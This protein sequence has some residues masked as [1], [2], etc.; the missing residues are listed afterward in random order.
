[1][2]LQVAALPPGLSRG[3]T[4]RAM[5]LEVA[6]EAGPSTTRTAAALAGGDTLAEAAIHS[7]C[8]V[9]ERRLAAGCDPNDPT[10]FFADCS[11]LYWAVYYGHQRR[12]GHFGCD[13]EIY[14]Q[15][16]A[17]WCPGTVIAT[18]EDGRLT[19]EYTVVRTTSALTLRRG[20]CEKT[21]VTGDG[22]A[23]ACPAGST[24]FKVLPASSDLLRRRSIVSALLV[25]GADPE[26]R[27]PRGGTTPL[28]IA[29]EHGYDDAVQLLLEQRADPNVADT[30]GK[31][32]LICAARWGKAACQ[33]ALLAAGADPEIRSPYEGTAADA[34]QEFEREAELK[35]QAEDDRVE[36]RRRFDQRVR[37]KEEALAAAEAAARLARWQAGL[38]ARRA[39]Y[40]VL[41][42]Q[43]ENMPAAEQQQQQQE[44]EHAAEH[45]AAEEHSKMDKKVGKAD[46]AQHDKLNKELREAEEEARE[47][48]EK[49]ER[50]VLAAQRYAEERDQEVAEVEQQH[51]EVQEKASFGR[52]KLQVLGSVVKLRGDMEKLRQEHKNATAEFHRAMLEGNKTVFFEPFIYINDDFTK[53]GSGQT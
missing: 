2:A 28:H 52:A 53:T 45:A 37:E 11:P 39:L 13:V 26:W 25:A 5:A 4:A 50:D 6:A 9:V 36:R 12:A 38:L 33:E 43:R 22:I 51:S 40:H 17:A 10:E 19:V 3:P 15:S 32:P 18:E 27:H 24:K 30:Y 20:L 48:K 49:E 8:E 16:C 14:S 1:M 44:E 47:R 41:P 34:A 21:A 46:K 35:R 7:R 42:R 31:T 23:V 29:T